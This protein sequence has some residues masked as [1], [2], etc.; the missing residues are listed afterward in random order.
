M[1][2]LPED[3]DELLLRAS[4]SN[5]KTTLKST[6]DFL[7]SIDKIHK[8]TEIG[9][10]RIRRAGDKIK[11]ELKEKHDEYQKKRVFPRFCVNSKMVI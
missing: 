3:L 10:E 11:A 9:K 2:Q 4:D 8:I 6:I 1:V 7:D 5:T